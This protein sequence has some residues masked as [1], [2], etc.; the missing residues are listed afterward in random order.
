MMEKKIQQLIIDLSMFAVGLALTIAGVF[1]TNGIWLV[2][3]LILVAIPI[4]RS[5]GLGN[6]SKISGINDINIDVNIEKE[7]C[8]GVG[9]CVAIAPQVFKIDEASLK[10]S[11]MAYAPLEVLDKKGASNQTIL[12]AAQSCPYKAI[13]VED[14][15]SNEQIFP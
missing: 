3:G 9:S 7:A 15:D 1:L 2:I 8:M 5:K 4:I 6:V 10:S 11:F 13:I 12:E 14:K